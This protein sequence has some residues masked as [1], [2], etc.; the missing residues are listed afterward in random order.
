M[1]NGWGTDSKTF[2]F[3]TVGNPDGV[4][5]VNLEAELKAYPNPFI[6]HVNV[7]FTVEGIYTVRICDMNGTIV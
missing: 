4:E 5:E 3:I 7:K 6:D 2:E 1:E